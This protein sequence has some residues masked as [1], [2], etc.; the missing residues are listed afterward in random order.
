MRNKL[1]W[2]NTQMDQE[3]KEKLE[4]MAEADARSRSNMIRWLILNEWDKRNDVKVP[5]K[6]DTAN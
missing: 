6:Q 2:V 4:S 3:T 5:Q 1:F